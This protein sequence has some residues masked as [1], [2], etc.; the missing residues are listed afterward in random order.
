MYFDRRLFSFTEGVRWRIALAAFLGLLAIPVVIWRLG[1][2]GAT[3]ARVFEGEGIPDIAGVLVLIAGLVLLR[4]VLQFSKEQV[5]YATAM[6]VKTR[7]RARLY[8]HVLQLGPGQFDRRRTGD[9]TLTLVDGVEQMET[10]FGLYLPQLVIAALTPIVI[11]AVMAFLDLRTAAVFLVFALATLIAPA[12]FHRANRNSSMARRVAYANLG[13]DFL[14][15]MQGLPTLKAFGQSKARGESLGERARQVYRSTMWVLAVNIATGGVTLLGISAGA[16]TALA[17]GA[18]RVE[19]GTLELRTLLI[20]LLLGVEVFRPLRD[21][22]VLYHQGMVATAAAQGIFGMLDS[23]PEVTERPAGAHVLAPTV[24][25]EDVSFTYAGGKRPAVEGLTFQ[26][27]EGET[28]GIVGPSGAGKSTLL[29][30]ILRFVDPQKGRVL[31]GGHDVRELSLEGLRQ[32]VAVVT[33]DTYL[34]H[35]AVA[36]N[37]RLGKPDA[38]QQE[39]EA[40]AKSANIHDFIASLPQGYETIVGERGARLS[41]GQRQRIAIARALLKDAPILV[42]DEALSS[43][44]A[45]NEATIQQALERLQQGRTT[46]VIAHRLSSV[47][48]AHRILVL[49]Q[50]RLVESGS[51]EDL[52]LAG[53]PYARL[54]AAQQPVEAELQELKAVQSGAS[55]GN[56]DPHTAAATASN[57]ESDGARAQDHEHH[58][59]QAASDHGQEE[60]VAGE[61]LPALAI[62]QGQLPMRELAVRLL[63]LVGPWRW[64]AALTLLVGLLNSAATVALGA[65]GA[66]LVRQAA[67]GGDLTG[68]LIALGVMV[69]IAA[70]LSWLDSWIAHDL[71]FR[72]LAE[73]RV[74]LYR[75]LDPLAPA[76]LLRRRSGD[77]VSAATGDIELIELFYAHTISPA[78]QALLV[79]GA[80]LVILGLIAWPLALV[81]APFLLLVSLTPL[82]GAA[83]ME[84]LGAEM[85][86]HTGQMNAHVVDSVQGLRTIAAFNHGEARRGEVVANGD[87]LGRF[88][89]RFLGHQSLEQGAVEVLIAL[90]GLAVFTVG[91]ALVVDGRM[92][93]FDLPFATVL[94]VYS[95]APVV[96]IVTVGKELMQTAAAARRYFAIQDEPVPV[97][98]GAGA[99]SPVTGRSV[100]VALDDVTFRYNPADPPALDGASFEAGAGQTVALVGRSGAGKST[101]AHLLMRFWD[102]QSGR[103]TIDGRDIREFRL[104]ELRR[105]I[106]LVAQDTYLFNTTLWENLKLGKPEATDEDVREAARLANVEEFVEALPD[107]FD[108]IVG[109]RGAQLSGGQ[110]QRV[111]IGRALLKDAPILVL[112]EATSHLDAVNEAEVR[113]ALERLMK[114]RT[115]LV[116]A[117]RLSTIRDADKIVVLD[118]G[119][120]I[121]QGK[122]G[123][124]LALDGLYSHLLANQLVA[125]GEAPVLAGAPEGLD[126][127]GSHSHGHSHAH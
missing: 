9:A 80:V 19:A 66:L 56:H 15:S 92:A 87:E 37:L 105:Q 23:K 123:E 90:G 10:F 40:A 48:S 6:L 54:M 49:E 77:L 53:G 60:R 5:A 22:T 75:L 84:K 50:G 32:Q 51:H 31:V 21:M 125:R 106:G 57:G 120:V 76:Y 114:G 79:P 1:L 58:H 81:L 47:R 44:D 86:S 35:G 36:E 69:P 83:R 115:T 78:F 16:A 97:R 127:G 88:K 62:E 104:D 85:R 111:A 61:A 68:Y 18:L 59:V 8:D 70:A 113:Q 101:A 26:L 98:D 7:L 121:E 11:F 4:A 14:D 20:V 30:L 38:S 27:R 82:L 65:V 42:M 63:K 52:I 71:A 24:S 67:L 91:A 55:A 110:R 112:D 34:F 45:E 96:N 89:L 118:A 25:F 119:R 74:A 93:R 108:T 13:S 28:L 103:I 46:L 124:L 17:W 117:H 109:E 2:T 33:Q 39:L 99:R 72:L 64:E 43:V 107:G 3:M 116:I 73:L 12:I 29:N 94:A 126:T 41:G 95:F 122:H 100:S 102:P